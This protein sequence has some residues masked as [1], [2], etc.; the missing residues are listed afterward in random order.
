MIFSTLLREWGAPGIDVHEIVDLNMLFD[1][2]PESTYGLVL[3][4]RWA[5]A[6]TDND[7]TLEPEGVWFANQNQSYSCA[8][9]GIMNIIMNHPELDLGQHLN[10]LR[11]STA[12][13]KPIDRG[14]ALDQDDTIRDVHNSFGTSIDKAKIDSK[15]HQDFSTAERKKKAAANG[16]KGRKG[17]K[18]KKT[19][20]E[21]EEN[22]F[23]FI[24]YVPA[25]GAVWKMDGMEAM[26]RRLGDVNPGD[27]WL[28][29]SLADLQSMWEKAAVNQFEV[30]L[31]SLVE[32]TDTSELGAEIRKME[33]EREDWGSLLTTLL[34]IHAKKGDIKEI[35]E[36]IA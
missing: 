18:K 26:P 7:I 9:V 8:T 17:R 22:G 4:T 21:E 3:L 34:K 10:Q 30:S 28:A 35:M 20:E 15:L 27:S 29:V 16:K 2:K 12:N 6:D 13:M 36:G 1:V 25:A 24:A 14:W 33:E 23:H 5:P 32:R 31:L 19:A 11:T